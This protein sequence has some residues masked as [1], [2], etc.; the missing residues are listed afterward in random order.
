MI[1]IIFS[2][3]KITQNHFGQHWKLNLHSCVHTS[4]IKWCFLHSN[5]GCG[6]SDVIIN[7]LQGLSLSNKQ[8][9]A[10]EMAEPISSQAL[11]SPPELETNSM[12][13]C[14]YD[15]QKFK[16]LLHLCI[17]W[18]YLTHPPPKNPQKYSPKKKNKLRNIYSK[19]NIFCCYLK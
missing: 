18:N 16:R 5:D 4:F 14:I 6:S 3:P 7:T 11:Q 12:R 19:N 2:S 13:T 9:M 17:F 15:M 10:S 1:K 8:G